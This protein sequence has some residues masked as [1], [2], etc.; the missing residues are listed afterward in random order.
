MSNSRVAGDFLHE[1]A[2]VKYLVSEKSTYHSSVR[3]CYVFE[4]PIFLTKPQIRS[5]IERSWSVR[6][7]RVRTM[8]NKTPFLRR[9]QKIG[10]SKFRKVALVTLH[11]D[12]RLS[13]F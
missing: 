10:C 13:F 6:V 8:I 5:A 3:N 12:D 4:V 9:S 7:V 2:L 11:R 1:K